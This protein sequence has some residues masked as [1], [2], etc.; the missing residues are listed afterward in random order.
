MAQFLGV[1]D[2]VWSGV[3]ASGITFFGVWISNRSNTDRLRLQL[4]N[5]TNEKAKQRR[6]D[7]RKTVYLEMVEQL[8][9]ANM[10]LA[11]LP[12]LDLTTVNPADGLSGFSAAVA[13]L[14]LIS[15]ID[16]GDLVSDLQAKHMALFMQAMVRSQALQ[17]LKTD[18]DIQ[19]DLYEH[20]NMEVKRILAAMAA[21]NEAARKD[22]EIFAAL[23]RSCEFQQKLAG[24]YAEKRAALWQERNAAHVEF[25]KFIITGAADLADSTVPATVAIRSELEIEGDGD[26][27]ELR[28]RKRATATRA[29]MESTV[30]EALDGHLNPHPATKIDA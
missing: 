3:I 13:K 19:N 16:T 4:Q 9:K 30:N 22:G 29:A 24:Q 6:G 21:F 17:R 2:V 1:P 11:A 18:I 27:I 23:N 28:L 5:D 10:H 15:T 20:A 25:S 12:N 26:D 8:V 14:Q 7:L